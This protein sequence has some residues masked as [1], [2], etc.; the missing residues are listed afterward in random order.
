MNWKPA[1]EPPKLGT[2]FVLC[3]SSKYM[4]QVCQY[5]KVK[6]LYINTKDHEP[7]PFVTHWTE[8][9]GPDGKK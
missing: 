9:T 6:K 1:H 2:Q 4:Y 3:R 8:I 7:F 5:D